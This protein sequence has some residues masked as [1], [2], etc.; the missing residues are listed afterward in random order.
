MSVGYNP[1]DIST[2]GGSARILPSVNLRDLSSRNLLRVVTDERGNGIRRKIPQSK[3]YIVYTETVHGQKDLNTDVR[4]KTRAGR[5]WE[6]VLRWESPLNSF[7]GG[8]FN[9]PIAFYLAKPSS[10]KRGP[11]CIYLKTKERF[12]R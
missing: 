2:S 4:R 6:M 8:I 12:L 3:H 9:A 7:P 5:C 1:G 11:G 10:K